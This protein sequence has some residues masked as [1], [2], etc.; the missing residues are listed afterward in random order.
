MKRF[1][2]IVLAVLLGSIS[3]QGQSTKQTKESGWMEIQKVEIPSGTTIYEGLTKNGNPKYWIEVQG[4]N[5]SVS[6]GSAVKFKEGQVKLEL[7][8]WQ[9]KDTGKIKYSTRQIKSGASKEVKNIDLSKI[10]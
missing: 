5:V 8:K 2:L 1:I 7:V 6:A 3:M 9:H 10:F 4:M